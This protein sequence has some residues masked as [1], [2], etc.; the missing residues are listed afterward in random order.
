MIGRV[1]NAIGQ[2]ID[3]AGP[4]ETTEYRPVESPAPGICDRQPVKGTITDR[5]QG[6]RLHDPYRKR[7]SETDH[8]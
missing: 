6:D 7:D 3:G 1:V 4:I 2:P 5:Y 8:R